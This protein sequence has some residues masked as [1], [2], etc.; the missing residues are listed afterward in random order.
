[1]RPLKPA[2]QIIM[3]KANDQ[4]SLQAE[5]EP[6]EQESNQDIV[7]DVNVEAG[8]IL[9]EIQA[10]YMMGDRLLRPSLVSVAKRK[11]EKS[12]EKEENKGDK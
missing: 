12:P 3:E 6:R 8:V 4:E 7:E 2:K 9:Q 1:M 10:G 5:E 11:N